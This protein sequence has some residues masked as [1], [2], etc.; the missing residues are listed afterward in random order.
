MKP[1]LHVR[2][3][4]RVGGG[5]ETSRLSSLSGLIRQACRA[6]ST[7]TVLAANAIVLHSLMC[8]GELRLD[9]LRRSFLL[10]GRMRLERRWMRY[11]PAQLR[12]PASSASF[13]YI[14][15]SNLA[16]DTDT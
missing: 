4:L 9:L 12:T 13:V 10:S 1:K 11:V 7:R 2:N 8:M 3:S 14:C 5:A 16:R 15:T 6:F